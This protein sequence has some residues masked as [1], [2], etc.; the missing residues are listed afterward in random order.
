MLVVLKV[1]IVD[2][3]HKSSL[4]VLDPISLEI[5]LLSRIFVTI[6]RISPIIL[7]KIRI[8]HFAI[9]I[10]SARDKMLER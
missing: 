10:C 2:K 6:F 7:L 1:F 9:L 8:E 4:I 3:T 5:N